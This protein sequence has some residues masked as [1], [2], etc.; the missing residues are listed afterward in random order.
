MKGD[1]S[2]TDVLVRSRE[3]PEL[4]FNGKL[5]YEGVQ[6]ITSIIAKHNDLDEDIDEDNLPHINGVKVE[7]S[8]TAI[9]NQDNIVYTQETATTVSE[10]I[11]TN[12]DTPDDKDYILYQ[13]KDE[14]YIIELGFKYVFKVKPD[15]TSISITARSN[16]EFTVIPET[17]NLQNLTGEFLDHESD[18]FRNDHGLIDFK[19]TTT[20]LELFSSDYSTTLEVTDIENTYDVYELKQNKTV[21]L[22]N[23]HEEV[24]EYCQ[25]TT[26]VHNEDFVIKCDSDGGPVTFRIPLTKFDTLPKWSDDRLD[27]DHLITNNESN[28]DILVEIE[29]ADATSNS[30]WVSELGDKEFIAVK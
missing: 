9:V 1:N 25:A 2:T 30:K 6:I 20:I 24:G 18:R 19:K 28:D 13:H 23:K 8:S 5:Q 7:K 16:T 11:R 12:S 21:E 27:I 4:P 14:Q 26:S 15:N 3:I 29:N 22:E 17:P 10:L